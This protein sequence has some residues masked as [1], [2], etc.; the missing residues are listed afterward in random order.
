MAHKVNIKKFLTFNREAFEREFDLLGE[1]MVM[2][3][4]DLFQTLYEMEGVEDYTQCAAIIRDAAVEF[5][6]ELDWKGAEDDRDYITE[7]EKFE[8][9]KLAEWR[10]C[11]DSDE[12]IDLPNGYN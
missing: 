1:T 2:M 10:E 12:P 7:L 3:G 8:Q 6:Y 4:A 9:K 11:Y 5:E